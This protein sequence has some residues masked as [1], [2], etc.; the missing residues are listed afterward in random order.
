LMIGIINKLYTYSCPNKGRH[1]VH[2][3]LAANLYNEA[4]TMVQESID[5]FDNVPKKHNLSEHLI[6]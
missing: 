5:N 3:I 2:Y 1:P 4:K 6:G